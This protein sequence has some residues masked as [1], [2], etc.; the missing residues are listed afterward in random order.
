[1]TCPAVAFPFRV[2][3]KVKALMRHQREF[4]ALA[5]MVPTSDCTTFSPGYID[6]ERIIKMLIQFS[7]VNIY[8]FRIELDT[9]LYPTVLTES[10][11]FL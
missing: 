2:K 1:M 7:N 3:L 10:G 4:T 8:G 9:L 5:L 6:Q 11:I